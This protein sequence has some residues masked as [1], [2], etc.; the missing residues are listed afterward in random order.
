M[1]GGEVDVDIRDRRDEAYVKPKPKIVAFSGAG[2]KLGR[3]IREG[4]GEKSKGGGGKR[5]EVEREGKGSE[6]DRKQTSV[7]AFS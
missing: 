3:K 7:L 6:A 5:E 4:K 2:R 1:R